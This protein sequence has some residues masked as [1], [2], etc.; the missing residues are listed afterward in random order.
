MNRRTFHFRNFLLLSLLLACA[1]MGCVR[2]RMNIR[3]NPPG[4]VV[5]VDD[6]EV[7][8]TPVSASYVH[9]GTREIRLEKDGYE[10]V[11]KLHTFKAPW[12]EYPVLEFFSENVWPWEIRDTR[13]LD[14]QM[15]PRRIVPPEELR[16]RAEQLRTNAQ[17]GYITPMNTPPNPSVNVAPQYQAQP[18]LAPPVMRPETLPEGGYALPPPV[19]GQ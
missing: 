13:D 12:Y 2:R 9:Y 4:A 10:S 6:Q 18:Q 17:A 8:V 7:G 3:T 1:S 14:F 15:T 11:S 5:Y 16:A 19:L